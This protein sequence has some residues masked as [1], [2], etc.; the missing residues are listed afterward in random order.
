MG[1]MMGAGVGGS[2]QDPDDVPPND[3]IKQKVMSLVAPLPV[4]MVYKVLRH[5]YDFSVTE[6]PERLERVKHTF[7]EYLNKRRPQRARRLFT[8]LFEPILIGDAVLLR[9]R[10]MIP[11]AIQRVDAA[12]LWVALNRTGFADVAARVQHRL[13]EMAATALLDDV[14][15]DPEALELRGRLRNEA[16][17]VLA[18]HLTDARA[19]SGFLEAL[20]HKR[21]TEARRQALY[22]GGVAPADASFH[23]YPVDTYTH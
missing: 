8:D 1:K 14:F 3:P 23:A 18:A 15:Q 11:G 2:P 13:D 17:R 9:A 16:V 20:N 5:L 7:I 4:R 12:G 6:S 22:L 10:R 21:L 19:L